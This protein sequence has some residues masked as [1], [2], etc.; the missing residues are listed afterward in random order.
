MIGTPLYMSPEQ[1]EMSGVD[2][3]TR[4]DIYSLGVVLYELLIG[5]TPF[6]QERVRQSGFDEIRR[7]IRE[8]EPP[9]PSAR[10]S[11]LGTA[12][13]TISANRKTD[14]AKL[15]QL[16]RRD[17]DW[18]VM[19][20]LAKDRTR[21]Y[22]TASDLARDIQRYLADEPIEA[23]PPTLADRAAKW[24]R[25]HTSLVMTTAVLLVFAVVALSIGALLLSRKEVEVRIE[26]DFARQ[27]QQIAE[28]ER[29]KAE[30]QRAAA[31]E[32]RGVAQRAERSGRRRLYAANMKLAQAAWESGLA[33]RVLE[34]L[35]T[36]WPQPGEED[37]RGFEW[38]YLWRLCHSDPSTLLGHKGWVNSVAIAPDGKT[39]ASG[40]VTGTLKLWD[41]AKAKERSSIPAH[42]DGISATVFTHYG[43]ILA[44][45][46]GDSTVSLWDPAS[47]ERRA[48]FTGQSYVTSLAWTPDDRM[49]ITGWADN[50]LRLW[51]ATAGRSSKG[52]ALTPA[53]LS[54][55]RQ[56]GISLRLQTDFIPSIA[57]APD[58]KTMATA[59]GILGQRSQVKL[60]DP[61]S[62]KELASLKGHKDLAI[63]LWDVAT[64]T[65]RA[66]LKGH[67]NAVW[68]LAISRNGN[69]LATGSFDGSVKLW[70]LAAR[71]EL[72]TLRGHAM[73]V[74]GVAF[75]PDGK[76]L[77]TASRDGTAILWDLES[78]QERITLH[79]HAGIVASVAFTPNGKTLATASVDR[80]VKLWDP[81]TGQERA[82]LQGHT[83]A[84]Y[85]VRFS[86]DGNTMA[87]GSYDKSVTLWQ[88]A[89][90]EEVFSAVQERDGK[91][92]R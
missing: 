82:T 11:T 50:A 52:S 76:T 85:C 4:S 79:G 13:T 51:D 68:C 29:A 21:R 42:T 77:A 88:A 78:R 87:A 16:L 26:R 62:G 57:F 28:D 3:D 1:A 84:V 75:A 46:G 41:M 14:P 39:L 20:A 33:P 43:S 81:V 25:R 40:D 18:I 90:D 63:R 80:T 12:A 23:R 60:W 24:A 35:E 10:V 48:T 6:D 55:D 45:V 36:H 8:E 92:P 56:R 30:Q 19:K 7:M 86:P 89:R 69:T 49:L 2:V 47:A 73:N 58:G 61:R 9:R 59:G 64:G 91:P 34:L 27:Q 66:L 54:P 22:Q 72:A 70:D 67:G 15:S 74:N 65:V 53:A 83:Q 32:Q 44:T 17:L 71:R 31:E 5:S 37:L 38:Y